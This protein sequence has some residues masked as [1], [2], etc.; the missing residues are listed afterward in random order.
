[1]S[2]DTILYALDGDVAVLRLNRPDELNAVTLD[3]LDLLAA[4]LYRAVDDG[5]RAVLITGEGRAFCRKNQPLAA[6]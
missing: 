5:A 3:M 1:M 4:S 6:F 2:D